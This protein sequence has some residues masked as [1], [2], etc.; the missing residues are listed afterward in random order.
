M[1]NLF[2]FVISCFVVLCLLGM[3][4]GIPWAGIIVTEGYVSQEEEEEE[5]EVTDICDE[6][7]AN[8]PGTLG[9]G[10][11]TQDGD[12]CGDEDGDGLPDD[13]DDLD[14]DPA[15]DWHCYG[16]GLGVQ[17]CIQ[18]DDNGATPTSGSC[19]SGHQGP[20]SAL[21]VVLSLLAVMMVTR[22]RRQAG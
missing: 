6:T 15:G 1:R 17:L 11:D 22:R 9:S 18:A 14:N 7:Q 10:D 21:P 2:R 4:A 5:E 16:L 3:T 8:E 20:G 13:L 19:Q 12:P